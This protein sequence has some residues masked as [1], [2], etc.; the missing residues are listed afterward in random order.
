MSQF[1]IGGAGRVVD[2]LHGVAV[3]PVDV[4]PERVLHAGVDDAARQVREITL[5]DG[6]GGRDILQLRRDVRHVD[7]QGLGV[8][9]ILVDGR[10]RDGAVAVIG[11]TMRQRLGRPRELFDR[12]VAPVD[13][14]AGNR[15][16]ARVACAQIERI[17][18]TLGYGRRPG[19][20]ERRRDFAH[21]DGREEIDAA[22]V[23]VGDL[24]MHDEAAVVGEQLHRNDHR[25]ARAVLDV[26]LAVEIDVVVAEVVAVLQACR[27]HRRRIG[28]IHE[29]HRDV[30]V[31][32]RLRGVECGTAFV[33]RAIVGQRG[34]RGRI[35]HM[36]QQRLDRLDWRADRVTR[37]HA[38][39][40]IAVVLHTQRL[41][42]RPGECRRC[43]GRGGV[44][45]VVYR[46]VEC[47]GRT[48]RARRQR[49]RLPFRD[50]VRSSRLDL[51]SGNDDIYQ[52]CLRIVR[53]R[54]GVLVDGA[55]PEGD[56]VCR[57]DVHVRRARHAAA[58]RLHRGTVAPIQRPLRD[59]VVARVGGRPGDRIGRP[60]LCRRCRI[61]YQRRGRIV[62]V[63]RGECFGREAVLVDRAHADLVRAVVVDPEIDQLLPGQRQAG[64]DR[65]AELPVAVEIPRYRAA[66]LVGQS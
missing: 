3:A 28:R 51:G 57:I 47:G 27:V 39:V 2:V 50:G 19:D 52:A 40:E 46:P 6:R 10:D 37:L 32:A 30:L 20:A 56:I 4:E 8:L 13:S 53:S 66:Q 23:L 9:P 61:Q 64:P 65:V 55:E 62:D 21:D 34:R 54:C 59:M 26:K 11:E 25:T 42:L 18:S 44:Y 43:A 15:V 31:H 7:G 58:E 36:Q 17:K 22:A 14:P 29:R 45:A 5:S 48:D 49:E 1:K 33:H 38:D 35:E 63:E 12:A 60:R 16:R 41:Q 24:A